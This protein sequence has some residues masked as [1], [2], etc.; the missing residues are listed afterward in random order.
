MSEAT[1][2]YSST[3]VDQNPDN[4]RAWVRYPSGQRGVC[5]ALANSHHG[6]LWPAKV[7][8]VS[9]GGLSLFMS[10]RFEVGTMLVVD[11]DN[12]SGDE[13]VL[14]LARVVRVTERKRGDWVMGCILSKQLGFNDLMGLVEYPYQ[15]RLEPAKAS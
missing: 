1:D 11:L 14:L 13:S 3:L 2:A 15:S 8:D 4:R 9:S 5:R 7:C 12:T 6:G 10:R